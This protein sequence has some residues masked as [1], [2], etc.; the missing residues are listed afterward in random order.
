M[1]TPLASFSSALGSRLLAGVGTLT[2]LAAVGLFASRPA[3]TAGGPVPVTVANAPL[4]V[5]NQDS[6]NPARHAV[7]RNITLSARTTVGSLTGTLY[8]VPTNKRLVLE[9]LSASTNL[10]NDANGYNIEVDT[11]QG[12]NQVPTFFNEVPDAAP[13]SSASQS[14]RLYADPGTQVSVVV[15]SSSRNPENF[16]VSFSGYLEDL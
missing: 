14:V 11:V 8:T 16:V 10:G 13:Y 12:G 1:T 6:D 5:I 7:G 9:H 15:Y 2:L 4:A 3:H